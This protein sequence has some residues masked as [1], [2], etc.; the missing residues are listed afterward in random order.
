MILAIFAFLSV[1]TGGWLFYYSFRKA[2]IQTGETQAVA[3]LKLLTDQLATSLSEHIKSVRVLS[4]IKELETVLVDTN[5]ET[6]FKANQILDMFTRSLELDVSYLMDLKGNTICS[7]NRNQFDSFVGHDFSFRPYFTSAIQGQPDSYLALGVTSMKRGVYY[8]HPVYH[9]EKQE[10]IGVAVIKS[11]IEFLE[12]TLFSNPEH[13][14]FFVSPNGII[15]ISNQS[16]YRFKLLWP[17]DNETKD[18]IVQSRQFGNGPWGWSGFRRT[19]TKDRVT[20]QN[21]EAYLYTSLSVPRYPDWR[22]VS[23]KNKKLLEKQFS[24]PFIKGIGPGVI[25]ITSLAGILVFFLYQQAAK[26]ISQRKTAE[27]KLRISEERY[28]HIYHKTPIMLH[29]IDTKGRIIRVSDHWVDV[30]GYDRD[31]VIGRHLTDFFT[32]ESKKF[33]L[34]KVFPQFFNTGFF[35]DIPYT[36]V[37]KSKDKMDILLSSYGVRDETGRVVRSLAV[38]V[39]VTEKNRTQKDLEHAKEKLARYSH[40]LEKQVRLRTAQLEKA[41]SSLKNLS[42]NIIASQEREKEQVAR[43]LHDHLGQVLTA[44]RIDVMWVKNHFTSSP[45]Q[46]VDRAE[47]MSLL[48]DKT[49]QD[50]RDMAYRLRPRVLDDLGLS[51]ALESLVSDFEKRSN[52]SCVFRRDVIPQIDKTLA[53][54]LYRIGQEAVTNAIRHAK[55]TTIIVE[56][57]T[58]AKGLVLTVEDNG[59]GFNPDESRTGFGLEGMMERANLAGGWLDITSQIGSGTRITCKVNVEGWS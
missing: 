26:E 51:D 40:D 35:K 16:R 32:P 30:M 25:F 9:P 59:I 46:A 13:L 24:A 3:Q 29:S 44:L 15:F 8:S 48:I 1:S 12:T 37:K 10:I 58:D 27:E 33:A 20:D 17:V 19:Q 41:Q 21:K 23:L 4:R 2:S 39:D 5:L 55:A 52:V 22:V 14:L 56:L 50:V 42:K 47:K 28:R 43:E 54:A 38:S 34:S 31:E 18:Q 11:S 7:S 49:I 36:Y 53:T 45:D 6:L 57:R